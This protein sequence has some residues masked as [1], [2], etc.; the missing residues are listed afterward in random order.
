MDIKKAFIVLPH[1]AKLILDCDKTWEIRSR[2]TK[3]RGKVG[4][5]ASKTGKIWG[6]TELVDSFPLTKEL[7]DK[8][9]DKHRILCDYEELPSNYKYVWVLMVNVMMFYFF[10]RGSTGFDRDM[11]LI[12]QLG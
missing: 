10:I 8:N 3:I 2:N 7:F 5:I 11:K 6:T 9:K 12:L 4:I 1:W